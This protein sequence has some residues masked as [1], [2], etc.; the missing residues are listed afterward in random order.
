MSTLRCVAAIMATEVRR[1]LRDRAALFFMVMLP[2]AIMVIIGATFAATQVTRIA[3]VDLDASPASREL[4]A[5]FEQS[6]RLDVSRMADRAGAV[7]RTKLGELA[8]AVVIP[9]GFGARVSDGRA[10][11]SVLTAS[12]Q[13]SQAATAAVK[14]AASDLGTELAARRFVADHIPRLSG[15]RVAELVTGVDARMS[16]TGVTTR[17]LGGSKLITSNPYT[18]TAAANLVLF[19]FVNS[20]AASAALIETRRLGVAR[21][22]MAAPLSTG[23]L[24]TGIT[25]ARFA[26]AVLQSLILIAIGMLFGVDWGSPVAAV[27][28]IAVWSLVSAGVGTLIGCL[29]DKPDTAAGVGVPVGIGLGMLGGCMWPLEI[30]PKLMRTIGHLTPH[31]WAVDGWVKTMFEHKGLTDVLTNLG[32][33]ALWAAV[34]LSISTLTLRRRLTS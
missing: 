1:V 28:L 33:L 10:N 31:A 21:R 13:Q 19:V 34:L 20:L 14:A 12:P 24:I 3:L 8:A 18:Y 32:V 4:V 16:P 27:A 9:H 2:A 22:M 30:V 15:A 17:N 25:A 5:A 7:D 6:H 23:S 29:V 11:V 26:V